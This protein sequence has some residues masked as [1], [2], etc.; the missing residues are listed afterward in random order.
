MN[1]KELINEYLGW[2]SAHM[3][4]AHPS[5]IDAAV[6]LSEF[7]MESSEGTLTGV[8]VL[9]IAKHRRGNLYVFI[10]THKTT[11]LCDDLGDIISDRVVDEQFEIFS[12]N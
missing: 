10:F 8:R 5:D 9:A 2:A 12:A 7:D 3:V 6:S 4:Y 1:E 11:W